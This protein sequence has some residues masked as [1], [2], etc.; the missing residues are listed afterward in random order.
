MVILV[1]LL[2]LIT[3]HVYDA[4]RYREP[5]YIGYAQYPGASIGYYLYSPTMTGAKPGTYD[6]LEFIGWYYLDE[7]GNEQRFDPATF[8]LPESPEHNYTVVYGRWKS[9]EPTPK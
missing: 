3:P 2:I 4:L 7:N 6:G 9:V 5:F 1:L 8:V